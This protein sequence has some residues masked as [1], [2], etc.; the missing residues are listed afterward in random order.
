MLVRNVTLESC[1]VARFE[2]CYVEWNVSI[3]INYERDIIVLWKPC[4]QTNGGH[5]IAFLLKSSIFW[6]IMACS[7]LKSNRRFGGTCR[8]HIQARRICQA[9]N[10]RESMRQDFIGVHWVISQKREFFVTTAVRTSN[11]CLCFLLW[12]VLIV[13]ILHI[14][15]MNYNK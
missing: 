14:T 15:A 3:V 2:W 5:G 8:L 13:W 12:Q 10:L 1:I 9:R 6:D 7:Q 4:F 11:L